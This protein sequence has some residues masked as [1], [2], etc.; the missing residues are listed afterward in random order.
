M[1]TMSAYQTVEWVSN[2]LSVKDADPPTPTA[3]WMLRWA[4]RS[5]A[6]RQRFIRYLF[7]KLTPRHK[8]GESTDDSTQRILDM[9]DEAREVHLRSH[10]R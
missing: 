3:R 2:N 4:Q 1:M 9:I 8:P 5:P 6:N 7:S 10:P